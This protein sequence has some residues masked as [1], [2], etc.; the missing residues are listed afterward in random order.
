[1]RNQAPILVIGNTS[2]DQVFTLTGALPH[3]G[4]VAADGYALH[5]GGQAAN[6]AA[7]LAMLGLPVRFIGPF[8]D[9]GH[10]RASRAAFDALG[11][12]WGLSPIVPGCPHH[13]ACILVSGAARSIV[14]YKD[15]R[16]NLDAWPVDAAAV[17][18][19]RAVFTDGYEASAS[20]RLAE[21][22]KRLGKTVMA[23]MEVFVPGSRDLLALVDHLIAPA[24]IIHSLGESDD[25]NTA[26]SH[27]MSLGPS[28]VVATRGAAG[29]LGLAAGMVSPVSVPARACTIVD[30]TGAGDAYHAGYLAAWAEGRSL[31]AC[32]WAA[33]GLAAAKC[34]VPGPRLTPQEVKD[35][36]WSERP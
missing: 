36:N 13:L 26:L 10:G 34:A 32:M 35:F 7:T 8:G 9:D 30:T 18:G 22:A 31:E 15:P 19:A 29:S 27:V 6:V 23:D 25:L 20:L 12:D 21:T 28:T 1:L 24:A 5:P 11:V 3:D 14:S 16:L 2:A 17:G 33:A 4:K